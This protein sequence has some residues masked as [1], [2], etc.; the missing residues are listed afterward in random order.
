MVGSRFVTKGDFAYASV[1]GRILTGEYAPGAVLNQEALAAAIGISTTPL[2]EGLRRLAS[3][4]L[5]TLDAHSNARVAPLTAEEA[6]DL[7]EVRRSMDAL[8]AGLAAERRTD[9]D[10]AALQAAA[11]HLRPLIEG[12]GPQ[13]LEA[14]RAFH[15]ALY[16]AS[17][18]AM[19]VDLLDG[20]WDK[21][22]R[23][24]RLGL[25]L[26]AGTGATR[27]RDFEEHFTLMQAVVRGDP[28]EAEAVMRRHVE[29]SLGGLAARALQ[30]SGTTGGAADHGGT[31]SSRPAAELVRSPG[32]SAGGP[33]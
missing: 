10:I 6:Q 23:Y 3:E 16:R 18:N 2:R 9:A 4:G 17:H 24:R 29:A 15:A 7:F 25:E 13:A 33:A 11:E 5:V 1:R 30:Q 14:H 31:T 12:V 32:P 28:V 8:A 21:S 27:L 20:L 22:D 26:I 19:L